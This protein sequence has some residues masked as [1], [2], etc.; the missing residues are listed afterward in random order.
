MDPCIQW[1]M[2]HNDN[3][4]L[5]LLMFQNRQPNELLSKLDHT[6]IVQNSFYDLQKNPRALD[7]AK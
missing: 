3:P 2:A 4:R 7:R 6:I 5:G 1:L